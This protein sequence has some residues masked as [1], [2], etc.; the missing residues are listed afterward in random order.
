MRT[1]L[2]AIVLAAV[3]CS[4]AAERPA[5]E[6]VR[7]FL[8]AAAGGSADRGWALIHPTARREMFGGDRDAYVRVAAASEWPAE[9][10]ESGEA[11][12]DDAGLWYVLVESAPPEDQVPAVLTDTWNNFHF[13]GGTGGV[14]EV[15]PRILVRY[16]HAGNG[17]WPFGG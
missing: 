3:S 6:Y 8:H 16:D 1:V 2:L 5:D 9:P 11:L 15:K 14:P 7:N 12:E 13:W 17:I 4:L 10:L